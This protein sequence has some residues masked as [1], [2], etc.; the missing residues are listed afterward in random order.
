LDLIERGA[1]LFDKVVVAVGSNPQK[2]ALFSQEERVN[3][4]MQQ[5]ARFPNVSVVSFGGLV[6][7][8]ARE[9]DCNIILR[10]V[11]SVADFEIEQQMAMTNRGLSGIE[12][13][14]V[15]PSEKFAWLSSR[16]IK[17]VYSYGGEAEEM[18]TPEV[19]AAV[20]AKLSDSGES[21]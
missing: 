7:H 15:M 11:R 13:V 5:T 18:L 21:A 2:S 9:Q 17:E 3:L 20:K 16:L 12:T 10:G 4:L 19:A 1:D 8:C 14:F 6:T